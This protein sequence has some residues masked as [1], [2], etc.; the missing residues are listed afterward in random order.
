MTQQATASVSSSVQSQLNPHDIDPLHY[1]YDFEEGGLTEDE[2]HH[3]V[4]V[5]PMP[6]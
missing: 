6:R 5:L 4:E 1:E 2:P 3:N